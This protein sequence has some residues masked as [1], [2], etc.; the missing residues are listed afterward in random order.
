MTTIEITSDG[1]KDTLRQI[2][3]VIGGEISEKWNKYSLIVNN[4]HAFGTIKY[5]PFDW[6][7]NLINFDIKFSQDI[8]LK[9]KAGDF[10]PIR[11]IYNYEGFFNHRFGIDNENR[12]IDQFHSLI[13]T[14]KTGGY[15]HIHLPKNEKLEIID[16]QII[17][18]HFLKKRTTNTS[19][20]NKRLY[21]IF[22]DT[23]HENRFAHHGAL[24]LKMADFVKKMKQ[25]KSKGM[26]KVLKIEALVYEMLSMHIQQHNK[27]HKG[28]QLPTSLT[29]SELKI[30]R[31]LGNKIIKNHSF[32]Y[33]LDQLS[34]DS[35][36]SQAKL[37]D[38]F[39]FL[40]TRTVTEY[41]RHVRLEA[42]R[43]L[44]SSGD[45][46]VSQV[47]YSIGFTSR[48]YFSKI[49]KE[50][51]GITPNEYRKNVLNSLITDQSVA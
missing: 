20:L 49:F 30:I 45:L 41:I 17:R 39:K 1:P 16:I 33:S 25:I 37:Q 10:N 4:E 15:N 21:E 26:V 12:R 18:K 28:V 42:A 35:G 9:I 50:K 3:D 24:N 38:G 7:V 6:G 5:V 34:I 11:F 32:N 13:F 22:V 47:V 29:K 19:L 8:T 43:D 23:D 44:M 2:Q 40:Y 31:R 36:L 51:Y 14:N 48:S 46:N 27:F